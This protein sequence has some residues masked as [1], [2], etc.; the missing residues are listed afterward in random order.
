MKVRHEGVASCTDP[1]SCAAFREDR[2]EALTGKCAGQVLSGVSQVRGTDVLPK[3]AR[4]EA[5][6]ADLAGLLTA[7]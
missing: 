3:V 4:R 2:R 1:K 5:D 7:C 6:S